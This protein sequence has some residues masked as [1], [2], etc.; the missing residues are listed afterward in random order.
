MITSGTMSPTLNKAIAMGYVFS[1]YAKLGLEVYIQIRKK[2][3]KAK[4]ISLPFI[5]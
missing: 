1:D 2:M 4:I 3:I 5:K